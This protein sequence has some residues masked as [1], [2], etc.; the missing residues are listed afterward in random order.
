[1]TPTPRTPQQRD[2]RFARVRLVSRSIFLGST[3]FS[4]ATVGYLASITHLHSKVVVT[5]TT[6]TTTPTGVSGA[7]GATGSTA[8]TPTTAP[9]TTTTTC[10][11]TPSGNT[12][13]N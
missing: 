2:R 6:T 7:T 10:Y 8:T 9:T 11:T 3:A 4:V 1:V 5:P 12:L 13:C